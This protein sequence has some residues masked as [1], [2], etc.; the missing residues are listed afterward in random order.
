MRVGVLGAGQLG[1]MLAQAGYPL[2]IECRFLAPTAEGAVERLAELVVGDYQ[3]PTALARLADGVDVATFEFENVPVA[4]AQALAER[5]PVRPGAQALAAT[6]DRLEE[7]RLLERLGIPVARYAAVGDRSELD[8]AL[9]DVGLPAVL[10]TR[11]LGYD[12]KGQAVLRAADDVEPAWSLLRGRALLLEALVPFERELSV[13]GVRGLDGQ[14]A[15]YPLVENHHAGGILRRSIAPAPAMPGSLQSLAAA[16]A[17][18]LMASLDYV[19][20]IALEL[21]EVAG[22]LLANE[23]APRVHNSGHWTIEGAATSQFEN[24][25]RAICGWPLGATEARGHCIM[26]NLIG[27]L[28]APAAMLAVPGAHLH[29][30]GK[31]PRPGRKVGHVTVWAAEASRAAELAARVAALIPA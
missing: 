25:L 7:R 4:A 10:K 2:G 6:Q 18:R 20:V 14:T 21:F 1:R 12:G 28:P 30:Y 11:R 19:G 27:E 24:H 15:C 31:Q 8:R 13:I 17:G 26:L 9:D 3:D 16:H 23:V 5:L 22:T 29:L